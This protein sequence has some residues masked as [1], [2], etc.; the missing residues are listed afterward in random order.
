DGADCG[1][2]FYALGVD[3][4][5]V[6]VCSA[7]ATAAASA[8]T[9]AVSAGALFTHDANAS[10]H[11]TATVNT[12]AV[13]ICAAGQFLEGDG[14]CTDVLEELELD[15][16]VELNAQLGTTI[17][18]GPHTGA[19]GDGAD[20][21]NGFYALGVDA[22][23]VA[24]CSAVA[25]AAVS[26]STAAVS[27]GALFTHD[28][29]AS[30]HHTATVNTDA[31][32]KCAA[33]QFL[34]G[35]GTCTDVLEELELDTLAELNAQLTDATLVT[36]AHT[37]DT[38]TNANTICGP[39]QFLEG[40]GTCTDVLE[41][42]ELDTLAELNAQL[43][44]ATLVTGAHTTDT[45]ANTICAASQFLEGD[46]TCTDVLEEL[47]LDT[48]AEL[49][50]QLT[51]AT[52]VTGA[53]TTNTDAASKCAPGQFLEGDDTCTDVLE[54]LELDTLAELNTQLTD[55][56]LVTGAHT[57]DTNTNA[58]TICGAGQ[59][60]EGDGTC[61]DVL[62]E[63]EL[64]TL[65]E[66]NTQLTDATLVTGAH[67]TDTNT[68]ANT[69]CG[70]GQFLEGD[71]TCTDVLEELE[72][73]TLAE[74]NAQ[75]LDATLVTGVH[76]TDT[77]TNA[78]T[79]CIVG[80]FLEGDGSCTD[81]PTTLAEFNVQIA[82]AT[83]FDGAHTTSAS[84]L[85][86][87]TLPAARIAAGDITT[88]KLGADAVTAVKLLDGAV[89]T[90]K[91]H[92]EAL[93][94]ITLDA[95]NGRVG[96][97]TTAPAETLEIAQPTT[98][99]AIRIY[100]VDDNV[101]DHIQFYN[102]STRVGEIGTLDG[103][104]LRINNQTALNIYTPRM[105]RADGG[106]QVDAITVI[107]AAGWVVGDQ[108][109]DGT[110][111]G[112]EIQDNTLLAADIGDGL[113]L[114]EIDETVFQQRV[115][116][117][118]PAGQSIRVIAQDGTVT[119]EVD[120]DSN[121]GDGANCAANQF[122]KGVDASGVAQGCAALVD[123]D[124]PNS[125]T[126]DVA[127]KLTT[128]DTR[129][130]A[131]APE[132]FNMGIISDFKQNT[133][134]GLVDGGTF[135]GVLS[136]R[137][138]SSGSDWSGGGVRQ[139]GFTD[140]HNLWIRGANADTVWS[141][142]QRI[143]DTDSTVK[144]SGVL[145]IDGTGDSYLLGSVGIGTTNPAAKLHVNDRSGIRMS[146][147]GGWGQ[148]FSAQSQVF[149]SNIYVNAADIVS[150]QVRS[151]NTHGT[152]GHA[153]MEF[154]NGDIAFNAETA[155][156]TADAIVV[157][158]QRMI[159]DGGTGNVGIG[160]AG[161]GSKLHVV[162]GNGDG[163]RLD[164]PIT[165]VLQIRRTD[166]TTATGNIDW[167]GSDG[168][169]DWQIGVNDAV[170]GS[171]D[172]QQG[173]T[174]R[175]FIRSDGNVGIGTTA[176]LDKLDV[177]GGSVS[178][179]QNIVSGS[180]YEVFNVKS[181]RTID[182]YGG[183]NAEYVRINLV[184]PGAATTGEASNHAF[185]DLRFQLKDSG[186]L[187]YSDVMTLR[188]NG[189]VGIG[190]TVP[191]AQLVIAGGG[192]GTASFAGECSGNYT[193]LSLNG[194]TG[195]ACGSGYNIM[196]SPTDQNLYLNTP[197][198]TIYFRENN[199]TRMAVVSGGHIV[200]GSGAAAAT[201]SVGGDMTLGG[202]VFFG[203]G[204][205]YKVTNAGVGTFGAT[206]IGNLTLTGATG[207]TFPNA[208]VLYKAPYA[209]HTEDVIAGCPP[210]RAANTDLFTQTFTTDRTADLRITATMIRS[211]SG[212]VDLQLFVN[213]VNRNTA[214]TYTPTSQW[215]SAN[216]QWTGNVAAGSHTISL[217]SPTANVWGCGAIYS[218]I[219]TTVIEKS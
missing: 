187:T 185:G 82:D 117:S 7:V 113:G 145:Q 190:V 177:V 105:F 162:A 135:H 3:A 84:L 34:E 94:P 88:A 209:L 19:H 65:A 215:V 214:I 53:H 168:V 74:L 18:D 131:D 103:S 208:S 33:G 70:A 26:A 30:A 36:G 58:N 154:W 192:T 54:E 110:V 204:G 170:S 9:A 200:T 143:L 100:Q 213:G 188:Y 45:N 193:A 56:T 17:A 111:D 137:Q 178:D 179:V 116:A 134:D 64:D 210:V 37:T 151:I 22:N 217:R 158:Q 218:S 201:G 148:T 180:V 167:V 176:P 115:T 40:D 48:L 67:T 157:P 212:R 123:A 161:P 198:G 63:L 13:T 29:N 87:G 79:L 205:S 219:D 132:S 104:W 197:S 69:I 68:N 60:L 173:A 159:I 195:G 122:N 49:N 11:H 129:A 8:S 102:G 32:S 119:C 4:N 42:L 15:T 86:T 10:A 108:I 141:S 169:V 93:L 76:T 153:Y 83:L 85:T 152:Y 133:T 43:T 12:N 164:A 128:A 2:G 21:G 163:I 196:S 96:I 39:G 57:T 91:L 90:S 160:T 41:E 147:W 139:L 24:V 107:D 62:E 38:N 112:S 28:A 189:N 149:G 172:I 77:N 20:C 202:S 5:G 44:D 25:T 120:T 73:D 97:G 207:I 59:F 55:A 186:G 71:G 118:C 50:T 181:N 211:A 144:T 175:I 136:L 95:T 92:G 165:P 126:V 194:V 81:I 72:L 138:W 182:D 6:A 206:S 101:A 80:Q 199:A 61:T 47:E 216:V 146:D 52:L 183:L 166:S 31:E 142:W 66:L 203:T 171:F 16:L 35:D 124:I 99:G 184:T 127:T 140:N 46:G 106:F 78:S 155:A 27:A 14:T 109:L 150:R 114:S 98:R 89:T 191:T 130:V 51:D 1:N 121:H 23:G 75:L 125:I 174:T 156:S